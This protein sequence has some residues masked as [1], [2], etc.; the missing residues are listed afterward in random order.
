MTSMNAFQLAELVA[1]HINAQTFD[2]QFTAVAEM[3][4]INDLE[5]IKDLQVTVM[6]LALENSNYSRQSDE[7]LHDIGIGIQVKLQKDGLQEQLRALHGLALRIQASLKRVRMHDVVDGEEVC[8]AY[9][10]STINPIAAPDHVANSR[11][12]TSVVR[13]TYRELVHI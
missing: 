2:Q 11:V 8:A 7:Q 10:R 6:P 12:F 5:T 1:Q 3:P 13:V 9:L 4:V